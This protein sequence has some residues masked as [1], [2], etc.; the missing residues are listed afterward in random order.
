VCERP[1]DVAGRVLRST[2]SASFG[3]GFCRC[4]PAGLCRT[5]W[6]SRRT[7]APPV[8]VRWTI[9]QTPA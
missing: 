9:R 4:E 7:P 5:A 1:G 2:A 6:G 8:A 3:A